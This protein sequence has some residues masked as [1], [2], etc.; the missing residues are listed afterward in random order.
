MQ[1]DVS[2]TKT[3]SPNPLTAEANLTY[4]FIV[5]NNGPSAASDVSL[6]DQLPAGL[7]FVSLT[8]TEGPP[9]TCSLPVLDTVSCAIGTLASGASAVFEV[10]LH[11][12][13][14]SLGTLLNTATV[15]SSAPFDPDTANNSS[16]VATTVVAASADVAVTKSDAPD[17]V[18]PGADLAYTISITNN[19]P[20]D[21]QDVTF[22]DATP[23][24]TTFV[25]EVQTTARPSRAPRRRPAGPAT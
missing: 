1:A 11:V 2:V 4:T 12:S 8:Q 14:T 6:F 24:S 18:A 3:A 5:T 23:P 22:V 25:S 13:E 10:V 17:P 15:S 16:S 19:G 21:A 7:A 20:S 9:A